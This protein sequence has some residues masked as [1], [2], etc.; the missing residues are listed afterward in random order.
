M[1]CLQ[2]PHLTTDRLLLRDFRPEDFEA[3]AS[4]MA[5]PDV[6]KHLIDGRPLSRIDAWRQMAMFI[7]HWVLRGY[8]LW[9]V[10]ER[11]TGRFIGRIGC[12]EMEGF[13]A[14]EIAYTLTRSAWGHGYAR[15]GAAA[16]L[17]YA[18]HTLRQR[19]IASIIRT[20]NTGSI[21]VAQSLGAIA[22]ETVEFFGAPSVAYWYPTDTDPLP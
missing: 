19:R 11:A 13:P 14:F 3:Y 7:G 12:L 6:S 9:A 20:G 10:E 18:R 1:T 17:G 2:I 8:G 22:G 16:A 5:D 21:R 15:E 4:M